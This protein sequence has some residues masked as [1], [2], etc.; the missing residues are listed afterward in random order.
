VVSKRLCVLVS[1]IWPG[2]ATRI[3]GLQQNRQ[4]RFAGLRARPPC[5]NGGVVQK[6]TALDERIRRE[7]ELIHAL[8]LLRRRAPD[9]SEP[10][11]KAGVAIKVAGWDIRFY[12]F[13]LDSRQ[14]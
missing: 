3:F 7:R 2:A 6:M 12:T 1:Q 14:H 8:E 5:Q 4:N 10:A 13:D 11:M 9:A